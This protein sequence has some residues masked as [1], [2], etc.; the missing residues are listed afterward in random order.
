VTPRIASL[1]PAGTD[2][3]VALGLADSL[4]GVS[5]ECDNPRVAGRGLPVLT[6]AHV[7]AAP[8]APPGEVDKAVVDALTAG[9]ALYAT[10]LERLRSLEP[11]VILAQDI[12]DVCA[13]PAGALGADLP[14]PPT[15]LSARSL[16]GLEDDLLAVA[17]RCLCHDEAVALIS[18]LRAIRVEVAGRIGG[19]RR[20]RVLTLEWGDPP[21]VGGHW[22]PELVGTAGGDH[23]LVEPG[24]RSVRS[25]WDVV[26]AANPEV[27]VFMPCGYGLE[28]AAAEGASLV[29]RVPQAEWWAVDAAAHFSRCTPAA[30]SSGLHV[31]AGILHPE[32][33][34][35]PAAAQARRLG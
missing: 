11:T 27:I 8:L 20:R 3:A 19:A 29:G 4:V 35:P 18:R 34:P 23:L 9:E 12:C 15:V 14:V 26:G 31:M 10:D 6:E 28:Q 5:H 30:V 2:I 17:D 33:C 1:V 21:F 32:L 22:V 24:D 16:A 7:A 13:L 25:T